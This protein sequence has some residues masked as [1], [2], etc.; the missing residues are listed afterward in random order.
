MCHFLYRIFINLILCFFSGKPFFKIFNTM[1]MIRRC[2]ASRNSFLAVILSQIGIYF[3]VVRWW[4]FQQEMEDG[5]WF[6][7]PLFLLLFKYTMGPNYKVGFD[8]LVVDQTLEIIFFYAC[9]LSS[10]VSAHQ[11][12]VVWKAWHILR[13]DYVK[14]FWT[15]LVLV[16]GLNFESFFF[17]L[18][19][20]VSL[21]NE[22]GCKCQH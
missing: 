5:G 15:C 20:A 10:P 8:F 9:Q 2:S 4:Q 13:P 12:N 3:L 7:K 11:V 19:A 6:L 22:N 16:L 1:K 18:F 14:I 17:D 21:G